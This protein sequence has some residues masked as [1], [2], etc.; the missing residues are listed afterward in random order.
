MF[1]SSQSW[2]LN[3]NHFHGTR[4]PVEEPS[5]ASI[6]D[7]DW[8]NRHV[9]FG[10]KADIGLYPLRPAVEAGALMAYAADRYDLWIRTAFF[11]DKILKGT[12]PADLPSR[13]RIAISCPLLGVKRTWS[14]RLAM[15]AFD[16]KRTSP[17]QTSLTA[18]PQSAMLG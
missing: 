18:A 16:P 8:R 4:V 7:I 3:S 12:Q 17:D 10:P 5:T 6:A 13:S 14:G 1:G 15:S 2:G 11:V 9:R